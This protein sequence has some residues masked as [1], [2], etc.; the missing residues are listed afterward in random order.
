MSQTNVTNNGTRN[1]ELERAC[2]A[3]L[4]SKKQKELAEQAY[5]QAKEVLLE[6]VPKKAK[7]L[8]QDPTDNTDLECSVTHATRTDLKPKVE[9]EGEE[10]KVTVKLL[11]KI[12]GDDYRLLIEEK[13]SIRDKDLF[14][15][16]CDEK[17]TPLYKQSSY[18]TVTF[19][20]AK[21]KKATAVSVS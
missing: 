13:P 19:K 14:I 7:I 18:S 12:L 11:Q 9:V 2:V 5:D 20:V 6:M 4:T 3:L 1:L 17:H 10:Q 21:P 15:E 16:H 8:F